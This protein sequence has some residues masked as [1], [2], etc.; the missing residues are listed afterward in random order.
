MGSSPI[1]DAAGI[2][3]PD[4]N[5]A[6][7]ATFSVAAMEFLS[8]EAFISSASTL[9]VAGNPKIGDAAG[10]IAGNSGPDW[11]VTTSADLAVGGSVLIEGGTLTL[12]GLATMAVTGDFTVADPAGHVTPCFIVGLAASPAS[13]S[14]GGDLVVVLG[15]VAV[16][17]GSDLSTSTIPVSGVGIFGG[18]GTATTTALFSAG[19]VTP[20]GS[21][22]E[23]VIADLTPT[24]GGNYTQTGTLQIELG[25]ADFASS[26]LLT[27]AGNAALGG[28]LELK[29]LM[30][31]DVAVGVRYT[32]LTANGGVTGTFS[33]VDVLGSSF[34]FDVVYLGNSVEIVAT[35]SLAGL[36]ADL[37]DDVNA[38][39]LK[40][41]DKKKLIGKLEGTLKKQWSEIR[42]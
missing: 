2:Q 30:S 39:D 4:F 7:G 38:S 5:V 11:M 13:A 35:A 41:G 3:A 17:P 10:S 8:G 19:L 22:G 21:T 36:V 15:E 6:N 28:T 1:G 25:G 42:G 32:I 20:G 12:D 18:S 29:S 34:G 24:D 14:I 23:L 37:I 26:D 40:K 27:V 16:G 33:E 31:L 9:D